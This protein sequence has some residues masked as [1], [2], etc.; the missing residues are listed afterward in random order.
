MKR[1]FK[2]FDIPMFLYAA[3]NLGRSV[4]TPIKDQNCNC[5]KKCGTVTSSFYIGKAGCVPISSS[6]RG[7]CVGH[8]D[9]C[10]NERWQGVARHTK[11]HSR[12][13]IGVAHAYDLGFSSNRKCTMHIKQGMLETVW[14]EDISKFYASWNNIFVS[15]VAP[16]CLFLFHQLLFTLALRWRE[17]YKP[18]SV[19]PQCRT[20]Y[21]PLGI[22]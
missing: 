13:H 9:R 2:A 17:K 4:A 15:P 21:V 22:P 7:V 1:Q 6:G 20:L 12:W 11:K 3:L 10:V 5:C 14:K 18:K 8:T 16:M 19:F